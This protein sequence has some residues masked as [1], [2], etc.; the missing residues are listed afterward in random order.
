M[1]LRYRVMR[2]IIFF[3]VP[4]ATS[5]NRKRYRKL[6][7]LLV[8]EGFLM[9]QYSVYVRIVLNK[10]SALFLEERIKNAAPIDGV[11][12]SLIIT[13][14]QYSNIKFLSGKNIDDVRNTDDRLIVI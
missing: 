9:I 1:S 13:E 6:H 7:Q 14:Q 12:Q 5:D 8:K 4:T 10:Q 11:V 3:D 2:L